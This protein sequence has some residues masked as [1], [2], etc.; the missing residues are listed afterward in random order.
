MIKRVFLILLISTLTLVSCKTERS[1]KDVKFTQMENVI[2]IH[3]EVMPKMSTINTLVSKLKI[4]PDSLQNET[5]RSAIS[6]LETSH[7]SMM[8]WMKVFSTRF[9]S[10]E[11]LRGKELSE[12]KQQW[13][14]EEEV[15][16]NVLKKQ[17]N[18]SIKR[19]ELLLKE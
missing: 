10:D 9:N 13:L 12:E 18:E 1:K 14:D 6:E 5:H 3:D 19:A 7:N 11:V 4:V 17:I 8:D 16:V 15:K 2:A